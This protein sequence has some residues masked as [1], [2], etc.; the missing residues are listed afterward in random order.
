MLASTA[1]IPRATLSQGRRWMSDSNRP[2]L[3][4]TGGMPKIG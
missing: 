3:S 4:A 2:N 1:L